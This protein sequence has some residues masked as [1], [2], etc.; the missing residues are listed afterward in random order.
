MDLQFV[1]LLT[2]LVVK[3]SLYVSTKELGEVYVVPWGSY[4]SIGEIPLKTYL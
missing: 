1:S 3:E 4:K 2:F